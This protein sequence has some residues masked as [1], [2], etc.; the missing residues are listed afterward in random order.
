[1]FAATVAE[2]RVGSCYGKVRDEK[3]G[4]EEWEEERRGPARQDRSGCEAI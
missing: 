3:R 4:F 2:N 1:M